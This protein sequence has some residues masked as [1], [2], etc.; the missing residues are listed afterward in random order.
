MISTDEYLFYVDAALDSMIGILDELGDE[1]ANKRPAIAG[2][3]SPYAIVNHCVGVMEFWGGHVVCGRHVERDRA[4]EFTSSGE[5]RSLVGRVR[6]AQEQ[7]RADIAQLEPHAKP[8]GALRSGH[9]DHPQSKTQ[10]GALIHVYEELAQHLGQLQITR[11]LLVAGSSP[12][13]ATA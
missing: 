12:K 6:V 5:V 11:D 9:D 3:N 10:G 13:D 4:A 7:L 1:L 8:R 2:A